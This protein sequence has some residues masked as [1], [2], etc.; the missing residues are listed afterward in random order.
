ML[1]WT[2]VLEQ[3]GLIAFLPTPACLWQ[4]HFLWHKIVHAVAT[5]TEATTPIWLT[6]P[7]FHCCL[8]ALDSGVISD[9]RV[10]LSNH[11]EFQA[12][13]APWSSDLVWRFSL[14]QLCASWHG[15]NSAVSWS[16]HLLTEF[17][18]LRVFSRSRSSGQ[19]EGDRGGG[20]APC[21]HLSPPAI[22]SHPDWMYKV[23]FYA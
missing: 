6:W 15:Q 8:G 11:I 9:Y 13:P 14:R 4:T 19:S 16:L 10:M 7:V 20:S 5:A 23:L 12:F 3:P 22:V 21:S 17:F 18:L 2:H 1:K